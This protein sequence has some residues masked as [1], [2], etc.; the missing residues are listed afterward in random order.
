MA[1]PSRWAQWVVTESADP[2]IRMPWTA[3]RIRRRLR[4]A[5][6]VFA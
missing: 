4:A 2:R 3:L 6:P 5:D 1:K